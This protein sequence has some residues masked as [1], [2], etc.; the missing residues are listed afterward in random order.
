VKEYRSIIFLPR[1]QSLQLQIMEW[2]ANLNIIDKPYSSNSRPIVF[3]THYECTF[4]SNDGC[5][6]IWIHEDRAPI[7]KKRR[8]QGL[9]VSDFLTP[10]GQLGGG[11]VCKVLKC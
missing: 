5:K 3:I 8:G 1:M 2:D 4:N 7:Q 11:N 6:K 10:V 9:H